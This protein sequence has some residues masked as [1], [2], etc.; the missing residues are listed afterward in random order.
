[1][2]STRRLTLAMNLILMI[3]AALAL[4]I[5]AATADAPTGGWVGYDAVPDRTNIDPNWSDVTHPE[6]FPGCH[7]LTGEA[8]LA[9]R[10]VLFE[11][12]SVERLTFGQVAAQSKAGARL[13]VVG[14]C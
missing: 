13:W 1:M 3:V 7:A 4:T 14:S 11:D 2:P 12:G 10:V 9:D 5:S 6:D 8:T